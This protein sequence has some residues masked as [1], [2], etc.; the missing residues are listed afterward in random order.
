MYHRVNREG[1]LDIW[2]LEVG[3]EPTEFLASEFN[4]LAPRL[5][6]HGEWLAYLSNRT[7]S[8]QV[9]VQP[10]PE[11]GSQIPISSGPGS[12]PM[13]SRDGRELF[14]RNGDQMWAV[15]IESGPD[16]R[17]GSPRLLFEAPYATDIV[18]LGV[19]NYDVSPDGQHFLMVRSAAESEVSGFTVVL[20]WF[21][22]LKAR[23]PTDN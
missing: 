9:Y 1:N 23:V 10:F 16:L 3:G 6:P 4:E 19:P 15:A 8:D 22:E 7:G 18:G 5:S 17:P 11:G 14:Y 13:W 12:E 20:N 2:T 21:E